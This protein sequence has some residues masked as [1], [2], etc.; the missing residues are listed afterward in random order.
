MHHESDGGGEDVGRGA[1]DHGHYGTAVIV[2]LRD[3]VVADAR[4]D[5]YDF[6]SVE[7]GRG[8]GLAVLRAVIDRPVE[9]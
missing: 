5:D 7:V 6:L 3:V 4:S 9:G 8:G 2:I 1:L